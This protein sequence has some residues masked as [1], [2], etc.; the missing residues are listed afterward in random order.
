MM[1]FSGLLNLWNSTDDT[2]KATPYE[3]WRL[4]HYAVYIYVKYYDVHTTL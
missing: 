1:R 4:K 3:E 2:Q